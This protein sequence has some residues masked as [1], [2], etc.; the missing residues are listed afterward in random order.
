[1]LLALAACATGDGL[2]V[3]QAR[4]ALVGLPTDD[5]RGCV[6]MLREGTIA[7]R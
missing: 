6:R 2:M 4:Q 5:L 3:N 1:L 7:T